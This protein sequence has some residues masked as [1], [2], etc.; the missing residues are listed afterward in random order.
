[1][2]NTKII[3][4]SDIDGTLIDHDTYRYDA[5]RDCLAFL[6]RHRI[7]LVLASSKTRAE[8]VPLRYELGFDDCPAIC[9]NGAGI[10]EGGAEGDASRLDYSRLRQELNKIPRDLRRHFLGFG[11]MTLQE[12]TAA[13]GLA[14]DAA[15]RARRRDFSEPGLWSGSEAEKAKFLDILGK[16]GVTATKGGRFL[17]LSFGATKADRMTEILVRYGHPVSVALGDAPNDREMIEAAD[18]GVI[19]SNPGHAPLPDLPGEVDGRIIRTEKPGP[20]GW[21]EAVMAIVSNLSRSK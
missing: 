10:V 2:K 13:T 17:T 15:E 9:E 4:F 14:P 7:P 20:A 11:D 1:M 3:I 18:Y 21:S 16:A 6:K 8:I 19:I 12:L 5:A